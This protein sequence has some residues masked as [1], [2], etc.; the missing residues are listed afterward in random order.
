MFNVATQIRRQ[1][2]PMRAFLRRSLVLTYAFP[3]TLL[4]PLLPPG[5]V[6]DTFGG[7]G[8][9]AIALLQAG[10]MRPGFLPARLGHDLFLCG[11]RLF[12]RF[13][14]RRGLYILRS[15]TDSPWLAR[16]GNLLARYRFELCQA[17]AS[18]A[19]GFLRFTIRTP[20]GDADLDVAAGIGAANPAL[21]PESPFSGH[22]QA[23][24]FAGPLPYTFDYEPETG[25]MITVLGRRGQWNPQPVEVEVRK[26]TFLQTE[27]FCRVKP[28][29][30]NAFYV[31]DTP[32]QWMRGVRTPLELP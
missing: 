5:L 23:R 21:P 6:L 10:R 30:A 28:V 18:T 20:H 8:F 11:Y 24:R 2:V 16:F 17:A 19:D 29:L 1:P 15:G 9:L 26:N 22:A 25:S 32:Y 12:V 3:E 31:H 13:G 7:S 27:P 4:R 14:A